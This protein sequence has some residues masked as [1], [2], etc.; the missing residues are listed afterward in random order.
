MWYPKN[1]NKRTAKIDEYLDYHH[2]GK[3]HIIKYRNKKM[4]IFNI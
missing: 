3:K 1:D 2:T 4:C